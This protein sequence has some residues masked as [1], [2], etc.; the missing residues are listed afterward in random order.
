VDDP[1]RVVDGAVDDDDIFDLV[2]V[3]TVETVNVCVKRRP[4]TL[5]F[6]VGREYDG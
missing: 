3:A 2:P 6:I 1:N 4:D 5:C